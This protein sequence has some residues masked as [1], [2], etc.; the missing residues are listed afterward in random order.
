[1]KLKT[2]KV[3]A[4][5]VVAIGSLWLL[6]FKKL[7]AAK[8]VLK[9]V[10]VN[11]KS[12]RNINLT[13][14]TVIFDA[15]VTLT[16]LSTIDFGATLTSKIIIKKIRVYN[17]NGEQLGFANTSVYEIDLPASKTIELPPMRVELKLKNA[18]NQILNNTNAF[19]NK[20]FSSLVYKIDVEVFGHIVTL[21]TIT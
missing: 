10:K 20:D 8:T 16:N 1:M 6:G 2:K 17:K 3:I 21:D 15:V 19:L 9:H 12:V 7:D 4:I 13:W 18:V 14:R 11:V 5:S